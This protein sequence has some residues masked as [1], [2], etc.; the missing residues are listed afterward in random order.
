LWN[1]P[2][3]LAAFAGVVLIFNAGT[4]W[5]GLCFLAVSCLYFLWEIANNTAKGRV[6]VV[7]HQAHQ[8][9]P[10]V[11]DPVQIDLDATGGLSISKKGRTP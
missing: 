7:V 10:V 5:K 9:A 11:Q 6:T 4:E 8:E 3:R 1:S 2:K